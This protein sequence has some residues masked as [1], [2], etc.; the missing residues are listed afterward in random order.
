MKTYTAE[1]GFV[2]QYYF[3]G[4]RA[5]FPNA[6]EA[7]ASEY[8]FDVSSDRKNTF[9]VSVFL[10]DSAVKSW[11]GAHARA[12]NDAERYAAAKLGLLRA[13]DRIP[14]MLGAGRRIVLELPDFEELLSPLI[15]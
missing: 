9:A 11:A 12:L 10:R 8:V 4:S 5:A 2:Y 14:D 6:P 13:F 1:T 7:P 15:E 3:V